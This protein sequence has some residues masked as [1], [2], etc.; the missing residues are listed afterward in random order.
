MREDPPYLMHQPSPITRSKT[1]HQIQF[2]L[3]SS[4]CLKRERKMLAAAFVRSPMEGDIAQ[5]VGGKT[6]TDS[7][8]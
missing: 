6:S 5:E 1:W 7:H 4:S 3:A 8:V 2:K